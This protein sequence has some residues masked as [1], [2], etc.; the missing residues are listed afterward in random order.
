M[1]L[2]DWGI[3]TVAFCVSLV[4]LP[5]HD[6]MRAKQSSKKRPDPRASVTLP[7]RKQRLPTFD[8][9]PAEVFAL[10][11]QAGRCQICAGQVLALRD[12]MQCFGWTIKQ[13]AQCSQVSRTMISAILRV[14]KFPTADITARLSACFG[15]ELYE[16]DLLAK[17]AVDE[18]VPL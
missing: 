4:L 14:L 8:L 9:S 18:E 5:E 1:S 16:F 12:L 2:L 3:N 13:L 17:W 7:K 6:F 11:R 15:L 10:C